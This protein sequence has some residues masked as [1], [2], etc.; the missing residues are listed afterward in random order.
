MK[1]LSLLS[2]AVAAL[3]S[4]NLRA[5]VV[6]IGSADALA[7]AI[8]GNPSGDYKLTANI[9]CSSWTSCDFS[10]TLDGNGKTISGL[11]TALFGTVSGNAQIKNLVISGATISHTDQKGAATS[12]FLATVVD[13]VDIIVDGITFTGCTL[14]E[15]GSTSKAGMV[16]GTFT[17]TGSGRIQN[18]SLDGTCTLD[19]SNAC[20]GLGGVCGSV[21]ADGVGV[22]VTLSNCVNRAA[23]S[24]SG[25]TAYLGG[26]V[27]SASC[28]STGT[29][30]ADLAH[31]VLED[32]A[33]YSSLT[34]SKTN[35]NFSPLVNNFSNSGGQNRGDITFR[36]C[37]NYGNVTIN[38]N[39]QLGG[40]LGSTGNGSPVHMYDC[41][42]YGNLTSTVTTP[43]GGLVGSLGYILN[44]ED[45]FVGCANCGD[46]TGQVVGGIAGQAAANASYKNSF[47]RFVSCLQKGVLTASG[48]DMIVGEMIAKFSQASFPYKVEFAGLLTQSAD[49]YGFLASGA[50]LNDP[51]IEGN[52]LAPGSEGNVDG[53]DVAT[54]NAF[55]ECDLWKQGSTGPILKCM[56]DE[57]APDTI[58]VVFKDAEE[59]GSAVLKT[60][61]I[62]RGGTPVAPAMPEHEGATFVRWNPESFT[63][64]QE[65]T[66]IV[67]VYQQG[68]ITHT[69]RFFDWDG[70]QI[71]TDQL[72]EHNKPAVA[73]ADPTR[74]GYK[75][76]GWDTDF[77]AVTEALDI[78]AEYVLLV[79]EVATGADLA[80]VLA[81][82][83]YPEVT[84][85]LTDDVEL[86]ATWG[87]TEFVSTLDGDGHVIRYRGRK[88]IF[89]RLTGGVRNVI[90]DG[91]TEEGE[92]TSITGINERFGL[93]AATCSGGRVEN[94]TIRNYALE[95]ANTASS[96]AVAFFCGVAGECALIEGCT[97]ESNCVLRTRSCT[98]A[99][100]VA[101][102]LMSDVWVADDPRL[103]TILSCTN[104]ADIVTWSSGAGTIGG[105]LAD[106][107]SGDSVRR[108]E[109]VISNCVNNGSIRSV[110]NG[111]IDGRFGGIVG[112]RNFVNST[113]GVF[114]GMLTIVDCANYGDIDAMGNGLNTQSQIGNYYGGIIAYVYRLG[115][116]V[117]RCQN[118]GRIG[119]LKYGEDG[120]IVDG[121]SGGIAATLSDLYG[122]NP[123][124]VTDSAN[125]GPVYG[126]RYAGGI[127]GNLGGNADY[128]SM[129]A[130]TT[131][132]AN[133]GV[134][135]VALKEDGLV[136]QWIGYLGSNPKHPEA[137]EF[138][139]CNCFFMTTSIV[140]RSAGYEAH[141]ENCK[142]AVDEGYTSHSAMK[143]LNAWA[144]ANGYGSWVE[145]KIGDAV[146][147]ELA[148]FCKKPAIS[149]LMLF[150]R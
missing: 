144:T 11:T 39:N 54:L 49:L 6:E 110:Y 61:V 5:E 14:R 88:P 45:V 86:E 118:H 58:T 98:A 53:S 96:L 69:V 75:F 27:A 124:T 26:L 71:G 104:N 7:E 84:Y 73:P 132:S 148:V 15:S 81:N 79:Q 89:S 38:A 50:S 150:F 101:S 72:V 123:V 141:I 22:V 77:S 91:E 33:N 40:I 24:I 95:L 55:R 8:T 78:T 116:T 37:V 107:S 149:G 65:D 121:S 102:S 93:V 52:M 23:V 126:G 59:F 43:V 74:E 119:S 70:S 31:V 36:R 80:E 25:F 112:S 87:G 111:G 99:G 140:G 66:D 19:A 83:V 64:L 133:Y 130:T 30:T 35:P 60:C 41:V 10:G 47:W 67:A 143:A 76:V 134:L 29:T 17:C 108:P 48:G 128:R 135:E 13:G 90:L 100:I 125:Y 1:K 20:G 131:N 85:L 117:M 145:G 28:N 103:L 18:V 4:F 94:V 120:D 106:A 114:G 109:I 97:V 63:E 113:S 137:N 129:A 56:P 42:N 127:F 115:V 51:I 136:G 57:P 16:A 34:V 139:A 142:T 3:V 62:L 2:A 44:T 92:N 9:D 122:A 32:C 68:T 12:G 147:P 46:L 138:G 146:Y 105:I 21:K 82:A